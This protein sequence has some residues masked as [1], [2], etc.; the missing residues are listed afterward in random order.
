MNDPAAAII[1]TGFFVTVAVTVKSIA[2]VFAKRFESRGTHAAQLSPLVEERLARIESAV[3]VIA[4][5]VERIAE[6]Q[7][8]ALRLAEGRDGAAGRAEHRPLPSPAEGRAIT[9]H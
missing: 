3:D 7:R 2:N 5:E 4:V 9:P 1:A 8:F 6:A